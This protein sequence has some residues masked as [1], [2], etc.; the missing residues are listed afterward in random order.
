MNNTSSSSSQIPWSLTSWQDKS[1]NQ[2]VRYPSASALNSAIQT[3]EMRPPLVTASEVNALKKQLALAAQGQCFLLQ[4]GDCAESF[5]ECTESHIIRKLKILLQISLILIHGLRLPVV[6]VG[7][8]A[9]QYAKPRSQDTE[10]KDGKTL[11]SYRGDLINGADFTE[12]ARMPNPNRMLEAYQYSG[13]TLNLIRALCTDGFANLQHPENWNLDFAK[14]SPKAADFAAIAQGIRSS[15]HFLETIAGLQTTSLKSVEFYTSHEA[16]HLP[17]EQALTREIAGQY[18]NLGTHFPWVGMRTATLDGAHFEYLRG[19]QNPIA[20]KIG[21]STTQEQLQALIRYLNPAMEWGRLT[22]IH[23]L[24]AHQ[25]ANL[26]PPLIAAAQATKIPVL[27]SCDPMHGNTMQ[28]ESGL[29]TR[30]FNTILSEVQQAFAIHQ[31]HHS[32]LGGVHFELTG[33]NVTECV[34]GSS[35]LTSLDLTRAYK[36][37]V[38]PRLNYDQAL[39]L[40]MLIAHSYAPAYQG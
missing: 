36:S 31:T 21:P 12:D 1:Y 30:D 27:W 3:L 9:G 38:D 20:I 22:L 5:A 29:K 18:Y 26:L 2:S 14:N 39:E 10:T 16:L 35:G 24:G 34:G 32:I 19:I 28:T 23:R 7:R 13:V 4:G 25:I 11:P 33:D 8:I 37:L 6:R 15:L 17:Y 40:A